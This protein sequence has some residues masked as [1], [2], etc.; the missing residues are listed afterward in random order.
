MLH[1][2]NIDLFN[3]IVLKDYNIENLPFLSSL[4]IKPVK[5]N[6]KLIGGFL[7]YAPL[8]LMG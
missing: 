1:G 5:V 6:L 7:L 4:V 2:T 3:P 8:A